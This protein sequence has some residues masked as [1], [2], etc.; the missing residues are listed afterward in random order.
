[1]KIY[2]LVAIIA[3]VTLCGCGGTTDTGNARIAAVMYNDDGSYAQGASVVLRSKDYLG[4]IE[5]KPGKF[6]STVRE[7]FTD[8][9]GYFSID[10]LEP[11]NY[12]VEIND[13][14]NTAFLYR[15]TITSDEQYGKPIV[16]SDTLR[17]YAA[18]RGQISAGTHLSGALYCQ[19]YGLERTTVV[20]SSGN[21]EFTDL[22]EGVF[23]FRIVSTDT[24]F[25]P[26][27]I[28]DIPVFS[29]EVTYLPFVAWKSSKKLI[30]NTSASGADVAG[31]VT[32]FPVLIRLTNLNFDFATAAPDGSDL[33]FSSSSGTPFPY[34]IERW[35]RASGHAEV[36]VSVD[37]IRGNDSTQH[38]LMYWGN[39]ES[40]FASDGQMVF[41][42]THGFQGVWH[43]SDL[44]GSEVRDA[45]LNRNNG[46]PL[47]VTSS[48]GAIGLCA[49]F[50]G[51]TSRIAVVNSEEGKLNFQENSSYTVSA[52]VRAGGFPYHQFI[53]GKGNYHYHLKIQDQHWHFAKYDSQLLGW[54]YTNYPA[55]QSQW[56]HVTGVRT[57]TAQYLYVDGV[58]VDSTAEFLQGDSAYDLNLDV[59]IGRRND[60]RNREFQYFLGRIDEVRLCNVA[61][62]PAWIK[63][64]YMNQKEEDLL[65]QFR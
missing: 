14:K 47:A 24:S 61:R 46:T 27:I 22:P 5:N 29:A 57:S 3:F 51:L 48:S 60:P 26:V 11:G 9:L 20:D 32:E 65:L 15:V 6:V 2:Y 8:A 33:R 19:I 63:L 10:F 37:T 36:W 40:S 35:D 54:E 17:P 50:D 38:I 12:T 13:R 31:T 39:P 4:E 18:V 55:I 62:G 56:Q 7:T 23:D 58:C 41:D 52:W 45:T 43:F 16:Y 30:L 1:M 59:E 21:F 42:T 64:S 25:A 49:E 34:E 28:N 53:V 44:G